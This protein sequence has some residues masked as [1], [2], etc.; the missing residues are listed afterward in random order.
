MS[1]IGGAAAWPLSTGGAV[2]AKNLIPELRQRFHHA[3]GKGQSMEKP[4]RSGTAPT[5]ALSSPPFPQTGAPLLTRRDC[6]DL[7][8]VADELV[9]EVLSNA[10][11]GFLDAA[12]MTEDRAFELTLIAGRNTALDRAL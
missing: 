9:L 7:S 11:G 8:G 10:I 3:G 2:Q 6:I 5:V 1:L 12:R 4:G